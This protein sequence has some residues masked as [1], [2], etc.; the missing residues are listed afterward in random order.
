MLKMMCRDPMMGSTVKTDVGL[1][2]HPDAAARERERTMGKTGRFKAVSQLVV[3]MNRFKGALIS[4]EH[5][6]TYKCGVYETNPTISC[7]P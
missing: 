6:R 5:D 1:P 2:P 4:P 7:V 3:A